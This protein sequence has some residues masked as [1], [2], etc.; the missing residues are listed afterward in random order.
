MRSFP[1]NIAILLFAS[2][3]LNA[4]DNATIDSAPAV[5]ANSQNNTHGKDFAPGL[6][7]KNVVQGRSPSLKPGPE[8]EK[9]GALDLIWL[10]ASRGYQYAH[11]IGS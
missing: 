4:Q 8:Q 1:I 3:L 2:F 11:D 6:T 7:S 10:N 9:A 5:K